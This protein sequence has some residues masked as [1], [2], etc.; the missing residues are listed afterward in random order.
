MGQNSF[1][2][3]SREIWFASGE[4]SRQNTKL[5]GKFASCSPVVRLRELS[6]QQNNIFN[7]SS[8]S[9]YHSFQVFCIS[10]MIKNTSKHL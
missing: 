4:L 5:A 8:L 9:S 10:N 3:A 2:F 7:F 6:R 1:Q